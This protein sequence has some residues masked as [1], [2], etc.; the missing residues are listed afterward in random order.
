[1]RLFCLLHKSLL[2][3]VF[4]FVVKLTKKVLFICYIKHFRALIS[5][6]YFHQCIFTRLTSIRNNFFVFSFMPHF[7]SY[8]KYYSQGIVCMSRSDK[9]VWGLCGVQCQVGRLISV[10][11]KNILSWYSFFSFLLLHK[12]ERKLAKT[13]K[14]RFWPVTEMQGTCLLA[15]I[16]NSQG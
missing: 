8:S 7:T 10:R 15:E 9:T 5:V 16:Y 1:M 6:V 14:T 3:F 13:R 12:K 2:S 11:A 4:H